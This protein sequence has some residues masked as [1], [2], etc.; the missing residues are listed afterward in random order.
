MARELALAEIRKNYGKLTPL[1]QSTNERHK[2]IY[3]MAKAMM[4]EVFA[5]GRELLAM[6]ELVP[7]G[8]FEEWIDQNEQIDYSSRTARQYMQLAKCEDQLVEEY[9]SQIY[10]ESMSSVMKLMRTPK[11]LQQ[12]GNTSAVLKPTTQDTQAGRSSSSPVDGTD[13]CPKTGGAH[14]DD[15]EACIHCHDPIE[16]RRRD[17][18]HQPP[19]ARQD[20]GS[21]LP[22]DASAESDDA[23]ADLSAVYQGQ[24]PEDE[25]AEPVAVSQLR[26]L[27]DEGEKLYKR[28]TNVLDEIKLLKPDHL[29]ESSQMSLDLSY[30]DFRRWKRRE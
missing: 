25:E 4:V 23:R 30:Q 16:G 15:Q 12:N 3:D 14:E 20:R 7:H 6:K 17:A 27:F 29:H 13:I 19:E 24:V 26:K 5:T 8:M 10:V 9:G 1:I 2:R 28:L 22:E 18:D 11:R 21:V